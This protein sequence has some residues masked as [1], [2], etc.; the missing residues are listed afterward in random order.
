MPPLQRSA[1][2]D[3]AGWTW[4]YLLPSLSAFLVKAVMQGSIL[5]HPVRRVEDPRFMTG[6]VEF[7]EDVFVEGAVHAVFVRSFMAHA[8]I[9]GID[10]EAVVGMPGVVDVFRADDLGLAPENSDEVPDVFARPMLATDRVRFVGEP[11]AV[12]VAETLAEAMDAAALVMVDYEPLPV[13][14]DPEAAVE[15]GAPL[16]FPAHGSNVAVERNFTSRPPRDKEP[17]VVVTERF[18][19][20]RIAPVPMETNGALATPDSGTG[21]LKMWIP[22]QAPHWMSR[23]ISKALNL[24]EEQVHVVAPAVGGGFGAKIATYPEQIVVASLAHR[25]RRPVRY[26]EARSESMVA[27]SQGRA[28]VQHV[29]LGATKEGI[30]TDLEVRNVADQGA[31]PGEGSSLSVMTRQMASGVYRIPHI[32]YHTL[33]VATNTTPTFAYRGAGRPEAAALIERA[34]DILAHELVMDPVD[35]RRRNFIPKDAFPYETA[36]RARYDIGDYE[37][38][39]DK[40]LEIAGYEKLR[41]EQ[42]ERRAADD[43]K[44]LGIGLSCYVELTGFGSD[45]S[46]VEVHEDG[47]ATA[48]TGTAPQGQGHETAWAQLVS[49]KLNIAHQRIK[50]VH[51]DTRLTLK[52][53]G[54][55]ASRSLQIGGSAI[56]GA[57]EAVLEKAKVLASHLFEVGVEDIVQADDGRFGIAGVPDSLIGWGELA[58][59]A[60]APARLPEGMDPGL[61][62]KHRFGYDDDTMSYPFGAHISVVEV[63]TET[64]QAE[65]L[66]HVAV[67]DCGR[68]LN[69]M[70]VEGQVHGGVA[71][72]IA[73][74]LFEEVVYD[75]EGNPLTANLATYDIPTAAELINFETA[76]TETPS[77]LNPLG[78]KGIG[79]SGTIGS[80]PAVQN[81][82]IDAV[83]HLGVRHIDMP[84]KP[85]RVW[86]AIREARP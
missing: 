38:A 45:S 10:L 64:G 36:S 23:E 72:G 14:V 80:T 63:D 20:Q 30:L 56:Y 70:L 15:E 18:S 44:Q 55:M 25:L 46:S 29:R 68:I 28:Q 16:L 32:H 67:D 54:T 1:Q 74:A 52:G 22:C 48:T 53:D 7:T 83:S 57:S 82:V 43:V 47:S 21:G 65:L 27:M 17:D 19:N 49:A 77:P 84:L 11:I 34:M 71:Q 37:A 40:A 79:E 76:H 41:K 60:S 75:E 61:S 12:V 62:A 66:R 59:A 9:G 39:L 31:Y 26:V 42:Q 2:K 69:P 3:G 73:Q 6:A 4:N 8:N 51:S 35:L 50:V 58:S 24:E 13:I 5:G 78:A 33:C 85:E 81:A 86:R